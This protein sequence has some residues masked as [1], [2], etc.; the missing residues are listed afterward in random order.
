V[1]PGIIT[2]PELNYSL[3]IFIDFPNGLPYIHNDIFSFGCTMGVAVNSSSN[4]FP[5]VIFAAQGVR[6]ILIVGASP[7]EPG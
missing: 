5:V 6:Q 7:R 2:G 3:A 1:V 4:L